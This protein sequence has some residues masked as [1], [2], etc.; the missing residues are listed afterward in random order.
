MNLS[1]RAVSP[2]Q[3][4]MWRRPIFSLYTITDLPYGKIRLKL[5]G[6]TR[7]NGLRSMIRKWEQ[8]GFEAERGDYRRRA[9][10]YLSYCLTLPP[11]RKKVA[12]RRVRPSQMQLNRLFAGVRAAMNEVNAT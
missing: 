9:E 11:E 2:V 10:T 1:G 4:W 3:R 12:A 5:G 6:G 8:T 7:H